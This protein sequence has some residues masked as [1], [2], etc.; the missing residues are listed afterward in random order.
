MSWSRDSDTDPGAQHLLDEARRRS[1]NDGTDNDNTPSNTTA[2]GTRS[3]RLLR[4]GRIDSY[5]MLEDPDVREQFEEFERFEQYRQ[6][7]RRLR[8]SF[9]RYSSKSSH[10]NEHLPWR[11]R[12]KHTTWAYF[13]ITMATGG[14]ANVLHDSTY[15]FAIINL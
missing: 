13:T 9:S 3:F 7:E 10:P 6:A 1:L 15:S 4:P 8:P 2:A 12:L 11:E 5:T 14:I